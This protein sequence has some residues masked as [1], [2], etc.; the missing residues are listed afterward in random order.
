MRQVEAGLRQLG[1]C[2]CGDL[3]SEVLVYADLLL[4]IHFVPWYWERTEVK[5]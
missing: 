3:Q 2:T 1:A 4:E 5:L